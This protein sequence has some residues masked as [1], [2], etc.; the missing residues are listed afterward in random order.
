MYV[1]AKE[2]FRYSF[3]SFRQNL[4]NIPLHGSD[5]KHLKYVSLVTE[6]K[7]DTHIVLKSHNYPARKSKTVVLL[8]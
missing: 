4:W 3:K 6:S 2:N 5:A 8:R 7:W 1:N